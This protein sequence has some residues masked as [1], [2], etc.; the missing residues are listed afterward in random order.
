[1][2]IQLTLLLALAGAGHAADFALR[3]DGT[4]LK[5]GQP[6]FPFG[7]YTSF[8]GLTEAQGHAA[9]DA[10]AAGGFNLVQMV[11]NAIRDNPPNYPMWALLDRAHELGLWTILSSTSNNITTGTQVAYREKPA[12][13]AWEINDDADD[14][15]WTLAEAQARADVIKATDPTRLT[16]ISLTGWSQ[17]RRDAATEWSAIGELVGPQIYPIGAR[18]N[19]GIDPAQALAEA[20]RRNVLYVDAAAASGH[21]VITTMQTFNWGSPSP[22]PRYPT[23]VESRNMTYGAL[24]AGA[25][26]LIGYTFL[27]LESQAELWSE[28]QRQADEVALLAPVLLDGER[29]RLATGNADLAATTWRSGSDVT[30]AVLN[31][32]G[33]AAQAV[34]LAMPAGAHGLQA[35]F[36]DR[37]SGLS[38]S[39]GQ[40][41]GTIEPMAVHVYRLSTSAVTPPAGGGSGGGFGSPVGGGAGAGGGSGSRRCGMGE[42]LALVVLL[43]AGLAWCPARRSG[44]HR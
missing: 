4:I 11:N 28:L 40:L 34:A 38:L 24:A 14:G 3:A 33:G 42:G 17:A 6:F 25:K 15:R 41:T 23:A 10:I 44:S 27:G 16:F 36:A 2:R 22:A 5:D 8:E 18:N 37:P 20:Y 32:S 7:F 21:A 26:G 43:G 30:V 1:M 13:M 39:D 12:I 9:L 19:A 35:L 31:L 29:S